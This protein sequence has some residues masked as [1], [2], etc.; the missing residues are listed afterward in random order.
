MET[1]F[2]LLERHADTQDTLVCVG[3]DPHPADL[4][5]P[6][7]E[8]ALEFCLRLVRETARYAAAFKPNAAFF[9]LYGPAGWAA[10]KDV[11]A[12]VRA[13]SHR[14][15]SVIPV[16][17]DAKRGDIASTA[18][19]YARSTF[20]QLGA[21]AVT[22]SPYLGQD[23]LAPFL[24]DRERGVFVLC[25][26]SNP[27]ADEIQAVPVAA[28]GQPGVLYEY[29]AQ[30]AQ[31]WNTNGNLGLVV[32]ATDPD[33]VRRVR[34]QAPGLWLL[35]P[36]V[37][38][39]GGDLAQ[40]LRAGLRPDGLGVLINVSRSIARAA[41]PR[42][43]VRDLR[44]EING[45]KRQIAAGRPAASSV[46]RPASPITQ[47]AAD[48]VASQC[49]Q[50]GSFTLKS[51]KQSPIYL[52]LR[53]LISHPASLRRAAQAYARLLE[54]L[55][56]DRIAGLPY[57]AL[58]IGTA[59]ALEMARPLIYPRR[60]VKDYGTQAAIEGHFQAGE[61]IVVLDDLATTGGTKLEAIQKL[62]AAGLTVRDIVVLIDRQQGA[63]ETLAA[64]GYTLRAVAT[65]TELLPLWL[66]SGAIT[67]EQHAAVLAFLREGV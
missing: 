60:E 26:T 2:S 67:P 25:K 31:A 42:E 37:G 12:A 53:R 17:L 36:G 5:H 56:F 7:A 51:G 44:D 28:A 33:A 4:P 66:A 38:A 10:L 34:A 27:G 61:T 23:S 64:A 32:G 30:R 57:A 21:H 41:R 16:I 43:A 58:P 63:A 20:E 62:E 39:Q 40:T 54:P 65:L 47:L 48:L 9:E 46:Q 1:F 18:D 15:G 29:I 52:D 19:A 24:T 35:V 49:V 13:E 45:L 55:A 3:L 59:V 6:T 22:L 11:I 8:A 50:F 14:L